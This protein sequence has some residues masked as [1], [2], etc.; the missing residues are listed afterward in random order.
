MEKTISLGGF[1]DIYFIVY[2]FKDG[3]A[4]NHAS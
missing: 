2:I 4:E 1:P 3:R